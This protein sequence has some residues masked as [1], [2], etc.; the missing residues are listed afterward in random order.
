MTK[1]LKIQVQMTSKIFAIYQPVPDYEDI[2][3][4]KDVRESDIKIQS[5]DEPSHEWSVYKTLQGLSVQQHNAVEPRATSKAVQASLDSVKLSIHKRAW[6]KIS[7][8]GELQT[9]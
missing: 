7:S 9:F 1:Y 3:K 8:M 2:F 6:A 4:A 5:N